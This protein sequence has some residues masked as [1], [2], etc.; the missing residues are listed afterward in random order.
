MTDLIHE[1]NRGEDWWSKEL[2]CPFWGGDPLLIVVVVDNARL[3]PTSSQAK[4]LESMFAHK[5]DIRPYLQKELFKHYR[6]HIY[7]KY[8]H[9]SSLR[10]EYGADEITPPIKTS[11]EIW[12]LVSQ[13]SAWIRHVEDDGWD[14]TTRFVLT[15]ECQ[16]D[17]EHG[18]RIEMSDWRIS[19]FD[20][21]LQ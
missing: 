11:S 18:L 14:G 12:S 13:P 21:E 20:A 2:P 4:I 3:G 9:Y 5:S 6:Q 16:W 8:T 1:L 7:G 19:S 17:D 10:G 15:F